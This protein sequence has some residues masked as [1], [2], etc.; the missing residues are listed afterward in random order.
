MIRE[1]AIQKSSFPLQRCHRLIRNIVDL[2]LAGSA[3]LVDDAH[4]FVF[5][6]PV[7][8]FRFHHSNKENLPVFNTDV[9]LRSIDRVR[10]FAGDRERI[11]RVYQ[12]NRGARAAHFNMS[13]APLQ[14]INTVHFI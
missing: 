7:M 3:A 12:V 1:T 6:L 2:K 4:F 8:K 10:L 9:L 11:F 5:Y 14:K 13:L